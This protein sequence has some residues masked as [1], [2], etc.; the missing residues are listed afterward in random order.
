M[1]EPCNHPDPFR[2]HNCS[3]DVPCHCQCHIQQRESFRN[4]IPDIN[5]EDFIKMLHALW[6]DDQEAFLAV[7]DSNPEYIEMLSVALDA[8]KVQRILS[9]IMPNAEIVA[10]GPLKPNSLTPM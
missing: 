9:S 7:V 4:M 8:I 5:E 1:R 10:I 2:C 3:G 6:N